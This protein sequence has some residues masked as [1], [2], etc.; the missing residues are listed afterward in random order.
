MLSPTVRAAAA[1]FAT[2]Q[3]GTSSAKAIEGAYLTGY[4]AGTRA[5]RTARFPLAGDAAFKRLLG[6]YLAENIDIYHPATNRYGRLLGLPACYTHDGEPF[7]DVEFYADAEARE[8]GGG[9]LMEPYGRIL[10]VLYAFEDLASEIVLAD[11][12]RVVPAVE[13]AKRWHN[14]ITTAEIIEN[15]EGGGLTCV[16]KGPGCELSISKRGFEQNTLGAWLI[17]PLREYHLAVGLR[18]D[19]YHRK[20]VAVASPA[21]AGDCASCEAGK[22]VSRG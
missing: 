11:G 22:E 4:C 5:P 8:E 18:P 1:A 17:Q 9:D 7:A 6:A 10:P 15:Y 3:L 14:G 16:C 20:P 12:R 13:V 19:Q 21:C 2:S